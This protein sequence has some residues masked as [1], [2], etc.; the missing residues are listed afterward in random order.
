[1]TLENL[2]KILS[3]LEGHQPEGISIYMLSEK[4]GIRV[5]DLRNYLSR[6]K[7]YFVFLKYKH[8]FALNRFG[9]F[10]GS[11]TRMIER[12]EKELKRKSTN[13]SLFYFI[14]IVTLISSL[15]TIIANGT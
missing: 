12:Y 7:G 15:T 11:T 1:M 8:Q 9:R 2:K 3:V 4:T 6:H 5:Y 14:M 10:K 13:G